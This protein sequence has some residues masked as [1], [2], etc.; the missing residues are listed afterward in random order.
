MLETKGSWAVF[1]YFVFTILCSSLQFFV[2]R[3]AKL[4]RIRQL[5]GQSH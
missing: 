5:F 3:F 2:H 4:R 1:L